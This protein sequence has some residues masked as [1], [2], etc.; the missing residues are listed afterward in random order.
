M[1]S[2]DADKDEELVLSNITEQKDSPTLSSYSLDVLARLNETILSQSTGEEEEKVI[3]EQN[4]NDLINAATS[5]GT[6]GTKRKKPD[7][8]TEGMCVFFS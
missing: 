6:S 1:E 8:K 7:S 2:K 3:P 4:I 5:L